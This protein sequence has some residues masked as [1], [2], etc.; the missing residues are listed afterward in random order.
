MCLKNFFEN[1]CSCFNDSSEKMQKALDDVMVDAVTDFYSRKRV[2]MDHLSKAEKI[3]LLHTADPKE[4]E[5][6]NRLIWESEDLIRSRFEEKWSHLFHPPEKNFENS[7]RINIQS[8]LKNAEETTNPTSNLINLKKKILMKNR[9]K[10][11]FHSQ[12]TAPRIDY[13]V[14]QILKGGDKKKIIP[15]KVVSQ[16]MTEMSEEEKSVIL[17][18]KKSLKKSIETQNKVPILLAIKNN[19]WL[20]LQKSEVKKFGT[21]ENLENF[22]EAWQKIQNCGVLNAEKSEIKVHTGISFNGNCF[23]YIPELKSSSLF[24]DLEKIH[25]HFHQNG[26][27][28][29][30]KHFGGAFDGKIYKDL[31]PAEQK[32]ILNWRKEYLRKSV[33]KFKKKYDRNDNVRKIDESS[34]LRRDAVLASMRNFSKHFVIETIQKED[35]DYWK[36]IN[37]FHKMAKM[38]QKK[39]MS[40]I[41]KIDL[42]EDFLPEFKW[43]NMNEKERKSAF[44]AMSTKD[45]TLL[46]NAIK[47]NLQ[48]LHQT[49]RL[50]YAEKFYIPFFILDW[51]VPTSLEASLIKSEMKVFHWLQKSITDR[52]NE[53]KERE[54]AKINQILQKH[55]RKFFFPDALEPPRPMDLYK[56]ELEKEGVFNSPASI[57]RKWKNLPD[58]QRSY[59]TKYL[60][61]EISDHRKAVEMAAKRAIYEKAWFALKPEEIILYGSDEDLEKHRKAWAEGERDLVEVIEETDMKKFEWQLLLSEKN[62]RKLLMD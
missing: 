5:F 53:V 7:N 34:Q 61:K 26:R 14:R 49:L 9:K 40:V 51:A 20:A 13:F 23:R 39:P 35:L 27:Y 24:V 21:K 32:Q 30:E 25:F 41:E 6:L 50:E 36:E 60:S 2:K 12:L 62:E 55:R 15:N 8:S 48:N 3:T 59:Y 19:D 57:K 46:Q 16:T 54:Q 45:K 58:E 1:T 18:K 11:N 29:Y 22:V 10:Y 31:T 38:A 42:D 44:T 43:I 17:N 4:A 52:E 28:Y 56:S 47:I 37:S 33:T